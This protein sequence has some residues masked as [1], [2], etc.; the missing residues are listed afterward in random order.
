MNKYFKFFVFVLSLYLFT[1]VD[2]F[3][4]GGYIPVSSQNITSTINTAR[5]IMFSGVYV[6]DSGNPVN[7]VFKLDTYTGNVWILEVKKDSN[8]KIVKNWMAI[9]NPQ[10][11]TYVNPENDVLKD[12]PNINK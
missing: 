7:A 5:F 3:S 10:I 2:S 8:G 11:P 9:E 4:T 12:L 6:D 1:T